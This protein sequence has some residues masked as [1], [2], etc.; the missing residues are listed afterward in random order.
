MPM[1]C[2]SFVVR[3]LLSVS[4]MH[5][6][7]CCFPLSYRIHHIVFLAFPSSALSFARTVFTSLERPLRKFSFFPSTQLSS[8][9]HLGSRS[10]YVLYRVLFLC[11]S[12]CNCPRST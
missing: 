2:M 8:Y 6:V 12:V 11:H 5:D 9:K 4:V 3:C 1:V 10:A 7:T